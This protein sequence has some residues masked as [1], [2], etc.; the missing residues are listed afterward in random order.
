MKVFQDAW[1]RWSLQAWSYDTLSHP[2]THPPK[3]E[4]RGSIVIFLL[5][6][7]A[8]MRCIKH[9]EQGAVLMDC[10]VTIEVL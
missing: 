5:V 8:D 10:N 6:S 4:T 1:E 7:L 3:E 9:V 2:D